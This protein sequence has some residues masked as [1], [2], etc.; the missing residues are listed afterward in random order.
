MFDKSDDVAEWPLTSLDEA[1]FNRL[2]KRFEPDLLR[3][4]RRIAENEAGAKDIIQTIWMRIWANREEVE[5]YAL[6]EKG[7]WGYLREA[8]RNG[9]KD[10]IKGQVG[11]QTVRDKKNE[12]EAELR[13]NTQASPEQ[14]CGRMELVGQ[15][16][17][18]NSRLNEGID[19][20]DIRILELAEMGY[21][22]EEIANELGTSVDELQN[23]IRKA[24][25]KRRGQKKY[26]T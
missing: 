2:V 24:R 13:A 5:K 4:T 20:L 26:V 15:A 18:K 21:R 6:T 10:R 3:F 7:M 11:L 19:S 1:R 17:D 9:N 22:Y 14:I 8:V 12:I 23:R 25:V 16:Q